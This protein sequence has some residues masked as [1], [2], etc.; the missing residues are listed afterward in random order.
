MDDA[1]K[2]SAYPHFANVPL[3][4]MAKPGQIELGL[5]FVGAAMIVL[6]LVMAI[7]SNTR[8]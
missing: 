5:R 3:R 4:M 7:H 1:L 6:G 2:G 8:G